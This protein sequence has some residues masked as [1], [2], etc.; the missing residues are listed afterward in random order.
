MADTFASLPIIDFQDAF[1]QDTKPRFLSDLRH[2]LV[3]TGFFYLKNHPISVG[4]QEELLKRSAA[5]FK[6]SPTQKVDI[7]NSKSFRGYTSLGGERT[8]AKVDERESFFVRD[9]KLSLERPP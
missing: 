5:F 7:A 4:V 8:A 3:K 9:I 6:L 1:S 2:A